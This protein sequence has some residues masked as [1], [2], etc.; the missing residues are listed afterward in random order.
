MTQAFPHHC[1]MAPVT[2]TQEA[3]WPQTHPSIEH[4]VPKAAVELLWVGFWVETKAVT[5]VSLLL[6]PR[7]G[8]G[9]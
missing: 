3:G 2:C 6:L 8:L 5:S 7:L 1:H 9:S 4:L